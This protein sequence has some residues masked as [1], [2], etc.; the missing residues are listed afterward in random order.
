MHPS[1]NKSGVLGGEV[2]LKPRQVGDV[3]LHYSLN[4][5]KISDLSPYSEYY[6]A[7]PFWDGVVFFESTSEVKNHKLDSDNRLIIKNLEV[8]DKMEG[9]SALD[10]PLKLAVSLLKDVDGDVNLRIPLKG[11]VNDPKFRVTPVVLK[12]FKDLIIKAVASPYKLLATTFNASEDDLRDIKYDYLQYNLRSRQ[13]K[14][15]NLLA[16]ILNQKKDMRVR[17]VHLS[18]PK[19]EINQYA[20]FEAKKMYYVEVEGKTALNFDDSVAIDGIPR[21]DSAFNNFL[22]RQV[23][24]AN[25]SSNIEEMALELVGR[26]KTQQLLFEVE[27]KR[28]QIAQEYLATKVE[29]KNRV[30]IVEASDEESAGHRERLK[31]IVLFETAPSESLQQ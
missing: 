20:L 11:D 26:E 23:A 29:D 27:Q 17:L 7:H 4:E 14:G 31:L 16:R 18:N 1:L 3:Y 30:V 13:T 22:V 5:L 8:G 21:L 15:L 10:L 19:W 2:L 12:I 24:S 25:Y 9:Q 28:K 6:V